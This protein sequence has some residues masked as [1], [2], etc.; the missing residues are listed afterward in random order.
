MSLMRSRLRR[1]TP[2]TAVRLADALGVP[3]AIVPRLLALPLERR[4]R[5]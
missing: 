5:P 2:K 3:T 4:H 1:L